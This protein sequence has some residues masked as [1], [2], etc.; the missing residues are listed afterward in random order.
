MNNSVAFY[1]SADEKNSAMG[2]PRK[3][4]PRARSLV[5]VLCQC[6]GAF[7]FT[8]S[9][10]LHGPSPPPPPP[11]SSVLAL[12]SIVPIGA[13]VPSHR[14]RDRSHRNIHQFEALQ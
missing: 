11:P 10:I 5:F 12:A 6:L 1:S 9:H 7:L 2:S 3:F 13:L 4:Y 8:V 14:Q